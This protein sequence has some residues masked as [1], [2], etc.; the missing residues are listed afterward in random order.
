MCS[1]ERTTTDEGPHMPEAYSATVQDRQ[2][3]EASG[4]SWVAWIVCEHCVICVVNHTMTQGILGLK[5]KAWA[6]PHDPASN[7]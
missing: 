7:R 3:I 1:L 5:T 4:T 2:H 6:G